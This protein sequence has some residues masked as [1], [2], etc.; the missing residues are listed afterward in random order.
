[1]TLTLLTK[2]GTWYQAAKRVMISR[3]PRYLESFASLRGVV[4]GAFEVRER[5]CGCKWVSVYQ[6]PTDI[7]Q[8]YVYISSQA[9]RPYRFNNCSV[10]DGEKLGVSL[11]SRDDNRCAWNDSNSALILPGLRSNG[12]CGMALTTFEL[13]LGS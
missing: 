8:M 13:D 11:L 3:V 4:L 6:R 10:V 7:L 1:M 9:T 2:I 5:R 12:V